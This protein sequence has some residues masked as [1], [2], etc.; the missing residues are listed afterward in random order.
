MSQRPE[1]THDL[2]EAI[3][4]RAWTD[5]TFRDALLHDPKATLAATF[6]AELP[7]DVELKVVEET[8]LTRY[9]V[10]PWQRPIS[11]RTMLK[12]MGGLMASIGLAAWFSLTTEVQAQAQRDPAF[13]Q[14][15][16]RDPK[17]ALKQGY[18]TEVPDFVALQTLEET[19]TR[20]YL[21]LPFRSRVNADDLR[22]TELEA[23]AAGGRSSGERTCGLTAHG[24]SIDPIPRCH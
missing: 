10:L 9:L 23:V 16:L 24:C 3:I 7:P 6:G 20:R 5:D 1:P 17:T 13:R 15:L 11:R 14:E 19:P 18:G 21:V 2:N 12:T 4:T 8:A 22:D